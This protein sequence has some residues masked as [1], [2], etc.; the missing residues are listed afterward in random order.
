MDPLTPANQNESDAPRPQRLSIDGISQRPGAIGGGQHR[1]LLTNSRP[2]PLAPRPHARP[3]PLRPI[4]QQPTAAPLPL[5]Q[6]A[7]AP[8]PAPLPVP[9]SPQ[10][11]SAPQPQPVAA[12]P[13]PPQVPALPAPHELLGLPASEPVKRTFEPPA[14]A[15]KPQRKSLRLA[16]PRPQLHLRRLGRRLVVAVPMLIVVAAGIFFWHHH[17]VA[18]SPAN[19][20]DTTLDTMLSTSSVT[21]AQIN[22]S[23]SV[24]TSYDF[25]TVTNPKIST[26]ANIGMYGNTFRV[27]GYGSIQND[28]ISYRELPA[29]VPNSLASQIT[30][31]WV[32][33]RT[34]GAESPGVT[35]ALNQVADPRYR[36]F[37]PVIFG[38]FTPATRQK[39]IAYVAAHHIYAYSQ[40]AITHAQID[41]QNVLVYHVTPNISYLKILN[42]SAASSEAIQPSDVQTVVDALEGLRGATMTMAINP[43]THQLVRLTIVQQGQTTTTDYS[44]Y[45]STSLADEP[46]TRLSWAT[47][48]PVQLQLEAKIAAKQTHKQIDAER[49]ADF[50]VL[51]NYLATYYAA[52]G[53]YPLLINMNDQRW[54]ATNMPGLDPDSLHDPLSRSVVV[55]GTPTS[56]H[57]AYQALPA[58][59][60]GKC[61]DTVNN[62][63]TQYLLTAILANKQQYVV[64]SL[65]N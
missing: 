7:P 57:Y 37:G 12:L 34:N 49:K 15:T 42:Q 16:L 8:T 23:G 45:G 62:P 54:L 4:Y 35:A 40:T 9:A 31:A 44:Q 1:P 41:K 26:E 21:A 28:Y 39:L 65:D 18:A 63:C 5:P 25:S 29:V 59:G 50:A 36:A 51:H 20:F 64:T 47:F 10:A 58:S 22:A 17:S 48:Q 52:N 61:D 30:N 60:K 43:S 55:T 2:M 38:N 27:T 46:V 32:Q 56:G 24:Q 6:P 14:P 11:Q 53:F 3:Q 19:I 33:L 13:A